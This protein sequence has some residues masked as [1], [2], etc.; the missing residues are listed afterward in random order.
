MSKLKEGVSYCEDCDTYFVSDDFCYCEEDDPIPFEELQRQFI[1]ILK[2]HFKMNWT[3]ERGEWE[4]LLETKDGTLFIV[5][6][7]PL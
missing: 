7:E 4:L 1:K 3:D 6:L 2:P 5:S